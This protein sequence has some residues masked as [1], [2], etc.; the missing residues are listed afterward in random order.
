MMHPPMHQ[1]QMY[2]HEELEQFEPQPRVQKLTQ[3]KKTQI[4]LQLKANQQA[5]KNRVR[6]ATQVLM[7][8]KRQLEQINEVMKH[9]CN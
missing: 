3:T 8:R 7:Q 2:E 9:P 5:A 6:L 1:Q 4:N